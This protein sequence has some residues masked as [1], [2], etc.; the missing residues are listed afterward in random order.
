MRS[1]TRLVLPVIVL[2]AVLAAIPSLASSTG[3]STA[4]ISG[5]ESRMWSPMEVAIT[6]GGTVTFQNTSTKVEH[7]VVW[8]AGNPE[9]P[10]CSGVPIDKGETNWQGTCTF[11]KE[12]TYAFYCYVHGTAMSGKVFVN[13]SGTI[14]TTTTT[15]TTTTSS[16]KTTGT[17][18]TMT[19]SMS[20]T[21]ASST[22]SGGEGGEERGEG[23]S[24]ADSLL[25]SS[26]HLP[27]SQRGAHVQG[28]VEVA[29]GGSGL[30]VEV[31]TSAATLAKAHEHQA[32]VGL[33]KRSGLSAGR[34]SFSVALDAK[35]V[36]ALHRKHRLAVSVRIT[37]SA[38]GGA[39]ARRT[40][41]V[42]LH[43]R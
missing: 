3:T 21:S 29:K 9:T 42:V 6:P 26:V 23:G 14:P 1:R 18:T 31:L 19:M 12:G 33:L 32:R 10:A 41:R 34:A 17:S 40:L 4:T 38:P 8:K 25:G 11:S 27:K 20:S 35:A 36:H 24:P 22:T 5:L 7:G 13:A 43:A 16:S 39:K 30:V 2:C 28:S 15:T 37:L